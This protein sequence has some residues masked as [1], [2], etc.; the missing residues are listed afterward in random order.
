MWARDISV[1]EVKLLACLGA[2]PMA[3]AGRG[4]KPSCSMHGC[5]LASAPA[6]A[7]EAGVRLVV[8][9]PRPTGNARALIVA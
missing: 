9:A 8:D 4:L 1:A 6:R 5:S 7:A 2:H 3:S